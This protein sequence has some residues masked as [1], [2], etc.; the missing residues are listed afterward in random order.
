[1]DFSLTSVTFLKA[2]ANVKVPKVCACL[3]YR[4]SGPEFKQTK[5]S[6]LFMP[7]NTV[8][9]ILQLSHVSVIRAA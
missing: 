9:L 3:L 8:M 2:F 1:M 4:L 7:F 5:K 6:H